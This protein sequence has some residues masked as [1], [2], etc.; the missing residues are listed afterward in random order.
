MSSSAALDLIVLGALV[1]A[2]WRGWHHGAVRE[3]FNLLGVLVGLFVAAYLAGPLASL[4]VR[5]SPLDVNT[6]RLVGFVVVA[7]AISVAG[8]I[9]GIKAARGVKVAA[10]RPN[11]VG[12]SL[13]SFFRTITVTAFV[14]YVIS[15]ASSGAAG[16]EE[17]VVD[18]SI[19][20]RLL[21][22]R[23]GPFT[24]FYDALVDSSDDLVALRTWAERRPPQENV[25]TDE[26]RFSP[27][28]DP[29]H[30]SYDSER[31]MLALLNDE[32]RDEGLDPLQWCQKCAVVARSHSKNMYRGGFFS[33]VDQEE[34]DPFDRMQAAD[35]D[36]LAAGENLAIAPTIPE[37]HERLMESVQ[38]RENILRREF[39]EVGIGIL[40]GPYGYMCTQVFRAAPGD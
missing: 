19:S 24:A 17:S 2:L 38:H 35:I 34:R 39:D 11:A 4:V 21:A 40:R 7:A 13:F 30:P 31:Q 37:A 15:V 1:T 10:R 22:S 8:A 12:G 36:Y 20:G 3:A 23:G 33:H 6:S 16:T 5:V 9:V 27:V 32:R 29:L 28:D 25:P 26:R 18:T 14:L